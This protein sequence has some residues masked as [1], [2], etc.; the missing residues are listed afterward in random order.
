MAHHQGPR[1][2]RRDGPCR[3]SGREQYR[4][5]ERVKAKE[6]LRERE[7][8]RRLAL[9][10]SGGGSWTWEVRS[11][12]VDWDERFRELYGFTADEPSSVE[13]W[14]SRV[15]E[16]DRERVLAVLGEVLGTKTKSSWD[17]TFRIVRPD[18]T[19]LWIQ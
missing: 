7:Q 2:L 13:A 1:V 12:R 18:G 15:H 6:A 4:V 16:E 8:R 17:N 3:A 5:T 11:G 9:D 14:P 19:V 10:A